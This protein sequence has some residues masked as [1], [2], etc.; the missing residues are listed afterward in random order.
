MKNLHK[1]LKEINK[2]LK[3]ITIQLI[4][5]TVIVGISVVVMT[6][7]A[8]RQFQDFNKELDIKIEKINAEFAEIDTKIYA[9]N[10]EIR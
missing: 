6:F 8:Y 9:E 7:N 5:F 4:A 1:D 10:T 3:S 2:I